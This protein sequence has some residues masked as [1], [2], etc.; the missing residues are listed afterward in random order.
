[1]IRIKHSGNIG[2]LIYSLPAMRKASRL[3]GTQVELIMCINQPGDYPEGHPLGAVM[4]NNKIAEMAFPL[5][6]TLDFVGLVSVTEDPKIECDYDFDR[7]RKI[8]HKYTGHISKWVMYVYP[9]LTCDLSEP[10]FIQGNKHDKIVF[11]R[12]Q[13]YHGDNFDY[14]FIKKYGPDMIFVG[15]ESEYN[16]IRKKLPGME[17][18]PVSDFLEMAQ[19]IKG[20]RFFIG[21][22]SMAFALAEIMKVPRVVEVCRFAHNVIPTGANGYEAFDITNL[23]KIL[24]DNI[25]NNE[26]RQPRGIKENAG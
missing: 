1:L 25:D 6:A 24:H 12:T 9:E 14:L 10:I 20:S 8:H 19:L 4:M 17:Y 5:L 15:L 7:F 26:P 18:R 11:N 3:H 23:Q 13:R 16:I 21:N 2:D 22:Q